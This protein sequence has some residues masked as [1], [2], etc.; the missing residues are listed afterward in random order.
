MSVSIELEFNSWRL[1]MKEKEQRVLEW[2]TKSSCKNSSTSTNRSYQ[3]NIVVNW[4][5]HKFSRWLCEC[6]LADMKALKIISKSIKWSK[7][8]HLSM[9]WW[10]WW[11][12]VTRTMKSILLDHLKETRTVWLIQN[13]F[14]KY[15]Y[16]FYANMSEIKFKR[17][18]PRWHRF[19]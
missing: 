13:I 4:S 6:Y 8:N 14:R 10:W 16:S 3:I 18:W 7:V 2:V 5:D 17:T 11:S 15:F 19:H 12:W 9:R 1:R